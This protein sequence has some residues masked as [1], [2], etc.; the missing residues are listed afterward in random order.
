MSNPSTPNQPASA[1][2]VLLVGH[3]VPDAWML[4]GAVERTLPDA[5]IVVVSQSD[6]L[7]RELA[8]ADL[9]LVNRMMDGYFEHSL[10]QNLIRDLHARTGERTSMILISNLPDAQA[11]AEAAGASPGFGKSDLHGEETKRRIREA[12]SRAQAA[13]SNAS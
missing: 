7:E 2:R 6:E 5:E 3:C 1:P 12:V 4:K 13:R 8:A 11:E 10:G 9:L